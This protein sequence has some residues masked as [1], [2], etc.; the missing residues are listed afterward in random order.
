MKKI[1][2]L[3]LLLLGSISSHAVTNI[4]FM[5]DHFFSPIISRIKVGDSITWTNVGVA[6]HDTLEDPSFYWQ[7][8]LFGPGGKY[9]FNFT[10]NGAYNYFCSVHDNLGMTGAVFVVT[11]F[12]PTATI[13]SPANNS[14]FAA[15]ASFTLAATASDS[16]GSV[17][18]VQFFANATLL[19]TVTNFSSGNTTFNLSVSNLAAGNYALKAV[20]KD[21]VGATN[22][23][24]LVNI[25]VVTSVNIV[26]SS[27][28]YTNGQFSFRYSVNP[29]VTYIVQGTSNLGIPFTPLQ[30]N[31]PASSPAT[32]LDT[33]ANPLRFY[34]VSR[35]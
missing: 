7:S 5:D 1:I 26:L 14:T 12:L 35:P 32:Y 10:T 25:S 30:T 28:T 8:P 18:N 27:P 34:R 21:N 11:N 6:Q 4:V 23:S 29:G 13:T 20:A 2:F 16:D 17:T 24:A 33:S 15:P 22:S 3:G 31:V 9:T 19:G